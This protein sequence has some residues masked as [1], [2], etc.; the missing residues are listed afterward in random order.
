MLP[1]ALVGV[2]IVMAL[3]GWAASSPAAMIV[4][5][6]AALVWW[7]KRKESDAAMA[8]L[9]A[10]EA[11]PPVPL[12][13]AQEA[14]RQELAEQESDRIAALV[15]EAQRRSMAESDRQVAR[16]VAAREGQEDT[17]AERGH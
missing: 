14:R 1:V 11:Q 4:F 9:R 16:L 17:E 10:Q 8:Q 12:T 15:V 7:T 6:V 2:L 3:I 5:A 13:P